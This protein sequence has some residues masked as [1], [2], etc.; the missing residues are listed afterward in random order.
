MT[1]ASDPNRAPPPW[2]VVATV[3]W[4]VVSFGVSA[5]AAIGFFALW[6]GGGPRPAVGAF[7]GVLLT[8]GALVSFPVQVAVVAIAAEL[9]GW[10]AAAYLALNVPRRAEVIVAMVCTI[11][12]VLATNALLVLFGRP[13][14]SSF[15]I[16]TYRSAKEAGWLVPLLFAIV[17]VAPVAEEIVF[18]G[19]AY[20]GLA[21]RGWELHAIAAIALAWALLH[22]QYDWF[23]MAQIFA[24]GLMLGFF[25]WASGSTSLT[26]LMHVLI[27]LEAMIET[28]I[29]VEVLT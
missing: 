26:I 23:G 13:I 3:A 8:L 1:W 14:V 24:I 18:R 15:Q 5:L 27:N 11:G 6:F 2:G 7:D 20:R 19:F 4:V 22:M 29:K 28:A 21:R 16:E 17:V 12:L 10:R 25:R 9:R